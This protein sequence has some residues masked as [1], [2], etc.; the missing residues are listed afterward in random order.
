M[1]VFAKSFNKSTEYSTTRAVLYFCLV[2]FPF[3]ML[4]VGMERFFATEFSDRRAELFAQAER[5]LLK[6]SE[7]AEDTRFFHLLLQK[8]FESDITAGDSEQDL[9][10]KRDELQQAFPQVFSFI[11]WDSKGNPI[12]ALSDETRFSFLAKKLNTLLQRIKRET[13][14]GQHL[15]SGFS[16]QHEKELR[17]LRQFLGPFVTPEELTS[18][19]LNN[20]SAR[21]FHLHARGERALGWYTAG[22]NFS[23]L[24]FVSATVRGQ[25]TGPE[26]L[27][28][29]LD[30]RIPGIEFFLLDEKDLTITPAPSEKGQSQ[31]LLNFGK[32]RQL[33][34]AEQLDSEGNYYNFQKLNHRWWAAAVIDKNRIESASMA[35]GR[36]FAL[37]LAMATIVTFVLY[38]YF[39][40]HENPLHSVRSRLILI[41]AYIVFIPT[42][43]FT[44]IGLDYLKQREKQIVADHAV[45][46]FQL[47]TSI[48]NQFK[49]FL[50]TRANELNKTLD[51]MFYRI[52][53][54]DLDESFL[55]SAAASVHRKFQ[56]DTL[57]ITDGTGK[58]LLKAAYT[59]SIKDDFLRKTA[60]GELLNYLN[61]RADAQY[62]LRNDIAQGFSL[63]FVQNYRR[64]MPFAL[65]NTNFLSY[66]NTLRD[67]KSLR[68]NN[69][70]QV[71][72]QE[73]QMHYEYLKKVADRADLDHQKSL[74]FWFP[75]TGKLYPQITEA[76]VMRPFFER[77]RLNGPSQQMIN[78]GNGKTLMA[79]GQAGTHLS[80]AIMTV[81][82]DSA[83]LHGKMHELKKNI[84]LLAGLSLLMTLSLFRIL[85]HYL[86]APVKTLATGVEMVKNRNYSFRIE[87]PFDNEFGRLGQSIDKTLENLQE[88]EIAR[89]VQESLLPQESI[90]FGNFHVMAKT[91]AMT[92]LG[93]DYYDYVVDS[94][95][96]LTILMADVAGHG[97]QAA[98]LM[99]MAKSVL[100]M[101]TT[102]VVNPANLMES[103]NKTFCTL[104]KAEIS[105]MMT[106]Q[107]IHISHDMTINFLNAGHCPPLVVS[108]NGQEARNVN[109]ASLPFGFSAKREFTGVSVEMKPGETMILYSDGILECLNKNE[110]ALG[111]DGFIKLAQNSHHPD[112]EIFLT[113]LFKNYENWTS[114]Q[115]DD[116]TFVLIRRKET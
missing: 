87:L 81:L 4:Y 23:V 77:I 16:E 35:T 96:N 50:F 75:D 79:F 17:L 55:A 106:G 40:V 70:I 94:A 93:G 34:A 112:P 20:S 105:T 111:A 116:M 63:S 97:V 28:C 51:S 61:C 33:A 22:K 71:F 110:E 38:C 48:D 109:N 89:T 47:L 45:Q 95:N 114:S 86:I 52:S 80:S 99:A 43:M 8:S 54:D 91:R 73:N 102:A 59:V 108:Q 78:I 39:L 101:K 56:P 41:F 107:V 85:G 72:W 76:Q 1:S 90:D 42:L 29:H 65:S 6:F 30:G 58:D 74:L 12:S 83:D 18:P 49:G 46:A 3:V 103:L 5:Q 11:F 27:R 53:G 13:A 44:V 92:S 15:Q 64:I 66:L 115:Q 82:I 98:L 69:L 2:A 26:Y 67:P 37:L 104:R 10:K 7:Y 9:R 25:L 57:I 31:L 19:F 113:N 84:W 14:T 60:A 24:V 100:L 68:F 88:L 32:F 36:F 21:C 62:D